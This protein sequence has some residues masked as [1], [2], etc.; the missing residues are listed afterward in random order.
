MELENKSTHGGVR[1]GAGRPR[2][3]TNKIT[4][5]ELIDALDDALGVPYEKQLANN[6]IYALTTDR[7]LVAAYDKLFLSKVIADKVDIT[8]GG[9]AL[10]SPT[11]NFAPK[12]IPDY[13]DVTPTLTNDQ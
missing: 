13:I 1:L 4:A 8:S 2:G 10:Q 11:L 6:Y 3:A 12:E 9:Q 5:S 7:N